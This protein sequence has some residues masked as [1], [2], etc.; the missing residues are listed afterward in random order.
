MLLAAPLRFSPWVVLVI[1]L[2]SLTIAGVSLWVGF[3]PQLKGRRQEHDYRD[4]RLDASADAVLGRDADPS[5]G[6]PAIE[7]ILAQLESMAVAIEALKEKTEGESATETMTSAIEA[8]KRKAK[9][10]PD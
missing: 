8:L 6:R 2:V 4:E 5:R 9:D 1:P 7:G 3:Y 10:D